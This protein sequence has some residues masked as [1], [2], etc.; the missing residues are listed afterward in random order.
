MNAFLGLTSALP[1]VVIFL[2]V[3][4]KICAPASS[5]ADVKSVDSVPASLV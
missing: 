2:G 3:R 1:A 5:S 4:T